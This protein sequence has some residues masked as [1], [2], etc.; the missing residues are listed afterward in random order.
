ME[1]M[2]GERAGR[3]EMQ[4]RGEGEGSERWAGRN[5]VKRK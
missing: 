3:N 5:K 4:K 2:G 1:E